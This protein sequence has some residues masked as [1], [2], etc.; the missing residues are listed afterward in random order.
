MCVRNE[1]FATPSFT[2]LCWE[3]QAVFIIIN[4]V[5][6]A[7]IVEINT[8]CFAKTIT[9]EML[10]FDFDSV[11]LFCFPIMGR[12]T[13]FHFNFEVILLSFSMT[14]SFLKCKT[15]NR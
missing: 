1:L 9:N 5:S 2:A 12:K 13:V 15:Q 3:Y 4:S 7:I 10:Q 8:E 6:R 11:N 14:N